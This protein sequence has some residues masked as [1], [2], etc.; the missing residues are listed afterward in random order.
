MKN[1]LLLTL[2]I[3]VLF[4]GY[5]RSSPPV[6]A[7]PQ[8]V[9]ANL[10]K[11]YTDLNRITEKEEN[12]VEHFSMVNIGTRTFLRHNN[13]PHYQ[14]GHHPVD[15]YQ[16]A[17]NVGG[18]DCADD[19]NW[20]DCSVEMQQYLRDKTPNTSKPTGPSCDFALPLPEWKPS[21]NN[22]EKKR[23]AEDV[24]EQFILGHQSDLKSAYVRDFNL[25]DLGLDIYFLYNNGQVI[26]QGCGFNANQ[27]PPCIGHLY[28]QA[29][30]E[31]IIQHIMERPYRLYPPPIGKP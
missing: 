17:T 28:G 15:V 4:A 31:P 2:A 16:G 5:S 27:H 12:R 23:V 3:T 7:P 24:L 8:S 18:F 20:V 1:T 9:L 14:E 29:P 22:D 25:S 11:T 30:L 19:E 26:V 21:P 10:R 13:A 6:C